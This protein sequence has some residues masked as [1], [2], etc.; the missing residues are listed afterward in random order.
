MTMAAIRLPVNDPGCGWSARLPD[1]PPAVR[2][3]GVKSVDWVVLGAGFMG[4]AAA[5]QLAWHRPGDHILLIDALR[6]GQGTSGRNSGFVIDLPHKSDLEG[7]DL[8]RMRRIMALN[9]EAI[10][11]LG[12]CVTTHRI[13]CQW[14]R[15][16]KYQ[17]AVGKRGRRFLARF[18]LLLERL[19]EPHEV[20]A[21]DQLAAALGTRYYRE[22]V[23]TPGS[24]LM[25]PAALVRGLARSLP[26]NVTLFEES[27]ISRLEKA[28]N[29]YRLYGRSGEVRCPRVLL[30]TNV[31]SGELGHL[32]YRVL[33]VMT[34]ASMTRPLAQGE[35]RDYPGRLDWG[36]TPADPAGTTLR[37]TADRRIVVRSQYQYSPRYGS[38]AEKRRVVRRVHERALRARYPGFRRLGFEYTWG[39]VCGLSRNHAS[40][41]GE[42]KPGLYVSACH[43]GVGV[44][45]GTISGKLLADLAVGADSQHLRDM[46]AVSGIPALNRPAPLFG[47]GVRGR[48]RLAQWISRKEL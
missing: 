16:G 22:A 24:I 43:N 29:Q 33:P 27:P 46:I 42:L 34:F 28:G 10:R 6:V 1:M 25:Q 19:G 36:L 7:R 26:E 18:R 38:S 13:D 39:G 31:F 44:A 14:S 37:M 47:L 15:A 41:F 3:A 5:R 48:M 35:F 12:E 20:L 2:L 9:R 32:R 17:G 11:F 21:G 40:Y 45:R 4:L 30:A 8:A 23:Y